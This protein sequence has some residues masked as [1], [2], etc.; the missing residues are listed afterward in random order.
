MYHVCFIIAN[1]KLWYSHKIE[2]MQEDTWF[3]NLSQFEKEAIP[4]CDVSLPVKKQSGLGPVQT[5]SVSP[6]LVTICAF[7]S[8][9]D[10]A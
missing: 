1:F 7:G 5:S 2:I 9:A 4:L 3:T 10:S 8:S 6:F